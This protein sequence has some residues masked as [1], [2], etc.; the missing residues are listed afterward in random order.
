MSSY[1]E[2]LGVDP[3][4]IVMGLISLGK[5]AFNF[6]EGQ[7]QNSAAANAADISPALDSLAARYI[8]NANAATAATTANQDVARNVSTYIAIGAAALISIIALT[9]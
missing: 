5:S 2:K 3:G 4:T 7:R 9:R 8:A 1:N 6:V